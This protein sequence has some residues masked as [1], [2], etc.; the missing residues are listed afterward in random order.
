MLCENSNL[1]KEKN[2]KKK[3]CKTLTVRPARKRLG[4]RSAIVIID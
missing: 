2:R 1:R 4:I 3:T